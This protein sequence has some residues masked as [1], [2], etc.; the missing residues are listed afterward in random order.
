MNHSDVRVLF[1]HLYWVRDRI[2]EAAD[3][4]SVPFVD[5]NPSTVRDLRGTLVHELDVEW[6][7]RERLRADDRTA[8][9][10]DDVELIPRDFPT[11]ASVGARWIRDEA[12]M[13]GWIADISDADLEG[14]CR[15]ELRGTHPLW[16][17]LQ[18]LY[19]HGIQQLSDAA[20][21]LSRSGRSPGDLDFLDFL[22]QRDPGG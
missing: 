1:D 10:P 13:R 5:P 17:H 18:H 2:L 20:V 22:E 21:I 4:P 16:F 19:A 15:A 14:P 7:W 11:L 12:E 9:P 3:A 8:F 6:S